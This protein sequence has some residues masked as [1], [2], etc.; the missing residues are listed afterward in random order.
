MRAYLLKLSRVIVLVQ[1]P[2]QLAQRERDGRGD[3]AEGDFVGL[4]DIDQKDVL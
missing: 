2:A 1:C 3:G 4:A